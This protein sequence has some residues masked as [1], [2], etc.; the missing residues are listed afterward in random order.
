MCHVFDIFPFLVHAGEHIAVPENLALQ[1]LDDGT[2]MR[3]LLEA[4]VVQVDEPRPVVENAAQRHVLTRGS[5]TVV[6]LDLADIFLDG[7]FRGP[8]DALQKLA[9]E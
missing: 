4:G 5:V 9:V 6:A 8:K 2:D 1:G 7:L 3:V